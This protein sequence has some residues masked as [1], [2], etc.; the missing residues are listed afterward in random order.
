MV[1]GRLVGQRR[2]ETFGRQSEERKVGGISD[3]GEAEAEVAQYWS[4]P[5][6]GG[7]RKLHLEAT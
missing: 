4:G 7:G 6:R 5:G 3:E 1:L 2:I